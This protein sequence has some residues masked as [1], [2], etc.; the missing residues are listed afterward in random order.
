MG[1]C[2]SCPSPD[3]TPR[4]AVEKKPEVKYTTQNSKQVEGV[5]QAIKASDNKDQKKGKL[6]VCV[7]QHVTE[8]VRDVY[9]LG[10][11]LGAGNFGITYLCTE[12]STGDDYACKT[13]SKKKLKSKD[14]VADVRKELQI[15][16]HLS[17]HPNIVAIKGAFEDE[18]SVHFVMELCAGGELFTRITEKG[19]YSEAAAASAMRTIVSVIE[20]CHILGVIHRDLKPENFLL[21]NKREDSPLKATDFGLSTFFKPGEVCK[22]VVGSAFYV[23]PEVLRRK[24][25]PESDI[26]S[27]GVILYI[28][29]SGVP[30]FWADTEDGIFAEVLK[31]KVDFDTDPWPKIS[32]DAKDL[33]R[34]ILNPDVKA[35]LTASEVL[36][37]PW[38]R[39]KGVA[40]TKPMDSSVQNRLKRFAA[41]NKMK[42]L[43]VRVIAQS[44]SEEEIAGL[45]NIFKIMDVD[46]SGTITF[47]ELKQG[48]QKVGSNMREADVRDLMDAA[49]VDKNGTIDYGEFLAATINMNKVER[50]ENMLAAFRYLDKDNSGYITGEELQNACAEFNM[51]EMNLEDLMRDVDLDNDGRIDYQ[52]FVAMMRKGTGTAPPQRGARMEPSFG[53]HPRRESSGALIPPRAFRP[54]GRY[55]YLQIEETFVHLMPRIRW[56]CGCLHELSLA[57]GVARIAGSL[58]S[59]WDPIF[60]LVSIVENRHEAIAASVWATP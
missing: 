11:K 24:Y 30:P 15:M 14:D 49:D 3:N 26:W 44:M 2:S 12:K 45:R 9:T 60:A 58:H 34:K 8:D 33:I 23:A 17:G 7:L 25:G 37:H 56:S 41:M 46:G 4:V 32:K 57:C 39:E 31:A 27:A 52:E 40:S 18:A 6:T 21:L 10:K 1:I 38:V 54:S 29:L 13:I 36:A 53:I 5:I 20:T 19:H 16:H 51:G 59:I 42:K 28:L 43:A 55:I 48:L 35:R 47:E 22:D 50:E